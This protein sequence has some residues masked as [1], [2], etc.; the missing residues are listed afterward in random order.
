MENVGE[1]YYFINSITTENPCVGE[2]VMNYDKKNFQPSVS[3]V[4]YGDCIGKLYYY[5]DS[6]DGKPV[7]RFLVKPKYAKCDKETCFVC[8]VLMITEDELSFKTDEEISV[9]DI[10]KCLEF[11]QV[12]NVK[13][14]IIR[15]Y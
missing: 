3:H 15:T 11:E 12:G 4:K 8:D 7:C 6:D 2:I 9:E 5:A 14:R 13:N 1:S 10:C